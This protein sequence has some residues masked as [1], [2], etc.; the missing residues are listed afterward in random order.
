M[1]IGVSR[2]LGVGAS[3]EP[4]KTRRGAKIREQHLLHSALLYLS[5][6]TS[7]AGKGQIQ[8]VRG[9]EGSKTR[10][11]EGKWLNICGTLPCPAL[12]YLASYG[13]TGGLM[14]ASSQSQS[15]QPLPLHPPPLPLHALRCHHAPA[16]EADG[17]RKVAS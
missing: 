6:S 5:I 10:M 1:Y 8:R 11:R 9:E 3:E 16:S 14:L 15:T 4:C 7:V 17:R 13:N 2:G 12:A